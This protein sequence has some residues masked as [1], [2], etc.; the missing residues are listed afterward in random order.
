[1]KNRRSFF[2]MLALSVIFISTFS[3]GYHVRIGTIGNSITE[4]SGLPD[5][6]TQSYPAQLAVILQETYGDTCILEN[7]GLTTTTMLKN[8]DVSYWDTQHLVDYLAFAPEICFIMLG[9][10][11]TKP[12]NWDSYGD[13]YF[14]DYIAMIDTIKQR[15]PSTKFIIAYPPPAFSVQWGIRDSIVLN[16]VIPAVDSV[17]DQVDAELVDFYYPLLDSSHLFP[18]DIHPNAEGAGVMA[19]MIHDK[20]VE[21]DII[22]KADTGLTFIT[23][24]KTG[25]SLL[26]LNESTKLNW[27]SI[28]AD[29]VLLNGEKVESTGSLKISPTETTTYTLI[30]NGDK[31]NDTVH[32]LQEVYTSELS[33]LTISPSRISKSEDDTIFVQV[34]YYDQYNLRYRDPYYPVEWEIIEGSGNLYGATDT[35]V[36]YAAEQPDT[37]QLK[38]SFE[39]LSAISTII[40][41]E[42]V[43][44]TQ[45]NHADN[46]IIIYP[47]PCNDA[48]N[49][50]LASASGPVLVKV[51]DIK[52]A[53]VLNEKINP[54]S[55]G[56]RQFD[57]DIKNLPEGS[58][59]LNVQHSGNNY[60]D[61]ITILRN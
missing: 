20:I 45:K 25:N 2:I 54:S 26:R 7:F 51:F 5:P 8:G 61:Q 31:S 23:S 35:S 48:L 28:N 60:T 47:N 37:S 41:K 40:T 24:F 3:Q 17:L 55:P 49:I 32:L 33:K 6:S 58:Y 43:T 9:T 15:N 22:H 11:D 46:P 44:A 39:D 52:G 12:Q 59:F 42:I 14:D 19:Q 13:E 50:Q 56:N 57:L 38:V 34:F 1:M 53:L 10:N 36:Y 29:S 16:G 4:G 30:A 18:D 21:T 27:T